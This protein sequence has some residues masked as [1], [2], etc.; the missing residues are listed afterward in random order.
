MC[1]IA[2]AYGIEYV[3]FTS[4]AIEPIDLEKLE[5]TIKENSENLTH[6]AV[7][8]NETTTGLLNNLSDL[9]DIAKKYSLDLIVDAM[10]SYAAIPINMDKQ[11]IAYLMASSNKNI[12]GM[13]GVGFVIANIQALEKIKN[14]PTRNFYLNLYSQYKNFIKTHQMR[15]TPPVQTLYA[16]KQAIVEAKDEGINARYD[17]YSKSWEVLTTGLKTMGLKYLVD[18]KFHSK[19]ITS[20]VMPD[21]IDF[22][23]MHDFLY[24]NG[25]TIYPGKV[26]NFNSFRIANIG[27]INHNDISN[28]LSLLKEFFLKK[29]VSKL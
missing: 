12:Q 7:I 16:L 2:K 26:E 28:A 27:D 10:S 22:N 17:R 24:E 25:V 14:I 6:M 21:G 13:A 20:I 23:E 4:S 19:I 18:D 3:E 9:G 29:N 1:Q 5:K 11:N 15:F 8:H